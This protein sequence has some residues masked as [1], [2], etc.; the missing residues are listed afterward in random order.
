MS[1]L[2]LTGRSDTR[3]RPFTS[4]GQ[5]WIELYLGYDPKNLTK[6]ISVRLNTP[7]PD[8]LATLWVNG[9]VIWTEE[10]AR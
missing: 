7:E 1:R 2:Y 8:G 9:K 4:R 6:A 5:K 10:A 3:K